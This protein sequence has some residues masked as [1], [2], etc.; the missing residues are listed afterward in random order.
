MHCS[1][2]SGMFAGSVSLFDL[3]KAHQKCV[4]QKAVA[5]LVAVRPNADKRKMWEIVDRV[6]DKCYND[7]EPIGRRVRR[8]SGDMNRAFR[9]RFHYGY[10]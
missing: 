8:N 7:L 2:A 5:S 9:E 10:D 3:K 6:F 1:I 4:K